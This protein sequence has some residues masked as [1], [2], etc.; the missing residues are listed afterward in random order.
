MNKMA[1][2][3]WKP[4]IVAPIGKSLRGGHYS[5]LKAPEVDWHIEYYLAVD[6]SKTIWI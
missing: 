1:A 3:K 6:M 4:E 5:Y 2:I